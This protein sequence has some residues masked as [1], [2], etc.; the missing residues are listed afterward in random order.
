[1]IACPS[2]GK[3]SINEFALSLYA[4]QEGRGWMG[5]KATSTTETVEV[6]RI[7]T[8]LLEAQLKSRT[9]KLLIDGTVQTEESYT[10]PRIISVEPA[11]GR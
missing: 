3:A 5:L 4:D 8:V 1:M 10:F 11:N 6:E 7:H 2:L 9:V